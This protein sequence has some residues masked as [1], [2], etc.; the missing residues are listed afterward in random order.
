MNNNVVGYNQDNARIVLRDYVTSACYNLQEQLGAGFLILSQAVFTDKII[1][2]SGWYAPEAVEFEQ[3]VFLPAY[4]ELYKSI[5]L[6]FARLYNK[7]SSS[8]DMW[9]KATGAF[10]VQIAEFASIYKGPVREFVNAKPC[11]SENNIRIGSLIL[12][13]L[14]DESRAW[15]QKSFYIHKKEIIEKF[16]RSDV[17]IGVDQSVA[18][19]KCVEE[20]FIEIEDT[21][22]LVFN[23]LYK[24]IQKSIEKYENIAKQVA[25]LLGSGS[26]ITS[27]S[28][29]TQANRLN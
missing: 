4:K 3:N 19:T 1:P 27:K 26:S 15:K 9:M 10:G 28:N 12:P 7:L 11:D 13:T 21:Y 8:I 23:K 2:K 24:E 18:L 25:S 6:R 29:L 22:S 17:F 5:F 16:Q 14:L 20:T